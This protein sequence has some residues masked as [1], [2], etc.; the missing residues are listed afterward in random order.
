MPNP[1]KLHIIILLWLNLQA[2]STPSETIPHKNIGYGQNSIQL[3]SSHS[4]S[5]DEQYLFK[6]IVKHPYPSIND[7]IAK[8]LAHQ[9]VGRSSVRNSEI[10]R[11]II[12]FLWVDPN[13]ALGHSKRV[14]SEAAYQA[15]LFYSMMDCS[16]NAVFPEKPFTSIVSETFVA[17][18]TTELTE[19]IHKIQ[20]ET[21]FSGTTQ[22]LFQYFADTDFLTETN[23]SSQILSM[24][25]LDREIVLT[26]HN[27]QQRRGQKVDLAHDVFQE[28]WTSLFSMFGEPKSPSWFEDAVYG[29]FQETWAS[30]VSTCGKPKAPSWFDGPFA[31]DAFH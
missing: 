29:I 8:S 18:N 6:C 22:R 31:I 3:Y 11:A 23:I 2:L 27:H 30:I 17:P 15:Q 24:Y 21:S 10:N 16:L 28:A 12:L 7:Q 19:C 20:R 1:S 5:E 26:L 14:Q 9:F 4:F 25:D 13:T